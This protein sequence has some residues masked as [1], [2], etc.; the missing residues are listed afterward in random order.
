MKKK[1]CLLYI[2][3]IASLLTPVK[4]FSSPENTVQQ[5]VPVLVLPGFLGTHPQFTYMLRFLFERG[6]QPE[7]FEIIE[8]YG[9]IIEK[10]IK[11]GYILDEDL[12]F[13]GFDWRLSPAKT[14]NSMDGIVSSTAGEITDEKYH[15]GLD[16]LGYYLL[17]CVKS[18]PGV[19]EVDLVCHSTGGIIARS[20]IQSIAYNG[21]VYSD[22]KSYR[23]PKVRKI[24]MLSVPSE[25]ASFA[26][27]PWHGNMINMQGFERA[28]SVLKLVFDAVKNGYSD[29]NGYDHIIDAQSLNDPKNGSDPVT[30]FIRLYM[31]SIKD[32]LPAY[33]FLYER[34]NTLTDLRGTVY[35][36]KLLEDL[37]YSQ[38]NKWVEKVKEA[39]VTFGI[40]ETTN[41]YVITKNG[42]GGKK[43]SL[44]NISYPVETLPG[45]TWYLD[46]AVQNNGD[47]VVPLIS[48]VSSFKYNSKINIIGWSNATVLTDI[49]HTF[50]TGRVDHVGILQNEEVM[51]WIV[52][53]IKN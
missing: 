6:V 2:V 18:N 42:T 26:W 38:H 50:T 32:L 34:D 37:N 44:N 24:I 31:P 8:E 29:V 23:L 28:G 36:N 5:Q 48:L 46:S 35:E 52:Q 33:S 17:Q 22:G 27:N 51:N 10:F 40:T 30:R 39:D 3:L 25:G 9:L 16:Y 41:T 47:K 7:V 11:E 1:L 21:K 43:V 49:N 13:A 45:E 53:R 15:Y 14:D 19:K 4:S 20:Y 12:F